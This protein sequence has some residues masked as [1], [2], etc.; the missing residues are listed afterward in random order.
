MISNDLTKLANWSLV[1]IAALTLCGCSSVEPTDDP[2]IDRVGEYL[3]MSK[4]PEAEVVLGYR[5]AQNNLGA[6]WLLLEMAI[7]SPSGQTARIERDNVS[8][9]TPAGATVPLA[10]QQ[11]FAADYSSLQAVSRAADVVRDPM[12]YWPPR[13]QSCPIQF[14]VPPGQAVSYDQVTVSDF[15]ACQGRFYFKIPG[16]VQ[17][18]RYVLSID[19]E[20]SEIRVPFTLLD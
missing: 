6:E 9:R 7:T 10:T 19:L 16:G 13:K 5:Y 11:E 4:G 20:E 12:D 1:A 15:R 8:L 14:F 17:P 3:L 2:G 18:G